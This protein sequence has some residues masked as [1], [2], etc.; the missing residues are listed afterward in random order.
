MPSFSSCVPSPVWPNFQWIKFLY[1]ANYKIYLLIRFILWVI[2]V[3]IKTWR[4]GFLS[5]FCTLGSGDVCLFI[6]KSYFPLSN[7]FLSITNWKILKKYIEMWLIGFECLGP[8]TKHEL[9]SSLIMDRRGSGLFL[10]LQVIKWNGLSWHV[11][12]RL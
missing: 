10:N 6:C 8:I 11:I 7:F 4:W 3:R 5:F 12:H 2:E 1:L 9:L